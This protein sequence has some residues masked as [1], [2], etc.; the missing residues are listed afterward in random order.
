MKSCELLPTV[1]VNAL[2]KQVVEATGIAESLLGGIGNRVLALYGDGIRFCVIEGC[3]SYPHAVE[4]AKGITTHNPPTRSIEYTLVEAIG[5]I[6]KIAVEET[7][8]D[9]DTLHP[10]VS[11]IITTMYEEGARLCA[12]EGFPVF[13]TVG[14]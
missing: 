5:I 6:T 3:N 14:K 9:V 1:A 12:I 10:I 13:D 8:F 11:K 7:N 4:Q 2:K